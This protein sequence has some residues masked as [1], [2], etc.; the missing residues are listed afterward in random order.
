M[1]EKKGCR[2]DKRIKLE[3]ARDFLSLARVKGKIMDV[4]LLKSGTLVDIFQ[5]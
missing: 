2:N 5:N 1:E 3:G 4:L